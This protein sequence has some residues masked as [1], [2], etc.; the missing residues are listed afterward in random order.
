MIMVYAAGSAGLSTLPAV[1]RALVEDSMKTHK[2][3]FIDAVRFQNYYDPQLSQGSV[4]KPNQTEIRCSM[5][6]G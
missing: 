4:L 1:S 5:L 6:A 3:P 2:I